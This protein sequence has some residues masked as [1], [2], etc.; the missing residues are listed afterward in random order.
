MTKYFDKA[1][2]TYMPNYVPYSVLW[3]HHANYEPVPCHLPRFPLQLVLL[4]PVVALF[5]VGVCFVALLLQKETPYLD[6]RNYSTKFMIINVALTSVTLFPTLLLSIKKQQT[7]KN[8]SLS[9]MLKNFRTFCALLFLQQ[10]ND[11]FSSCSRKW[12]R[13]GLVMRDIFFAEWVSKF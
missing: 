8:A 1:M 4:V 6:F 12:F 2:S 3:A 7:F 10:A 13:S 11:I 9:S 5:G